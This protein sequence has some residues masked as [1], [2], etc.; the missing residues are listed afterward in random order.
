MSGSKVLGEVICKG[1]SILNFGVFSLDIQ[2]PAK[3]RSL[4]V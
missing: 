3:A 1:T 4:D 2:T